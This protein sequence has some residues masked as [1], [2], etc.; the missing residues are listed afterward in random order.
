[1]PS[2]ASGATTATTLASYI[3]S[4]G[5]LTPNDTYVGFNITANETFI[6]TDTASGHTGAIEI[7]GVAFQH[8]VL[9]G[10][11]LTLLT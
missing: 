8:S 3:Q 11:T 10:H 6:V 5:T 1:M 4:L 9:A 7:M 2:S